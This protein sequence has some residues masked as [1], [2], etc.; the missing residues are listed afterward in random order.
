MNL[1]DKLRSA[2]N[3]IYTLQT[4]FLLSTTTPMFSQQKSSDNPFYKVANFVR[5]N[6]QELVMDKDGAP[7]YHYSDNPNSEFQGI[8]TYYDTNKNN[9]IDSL[10]ILTYL[11][12]IENFVY[13]DRGVNGYSNND[14]QGD[15]V[16]VMMAAKFIM[17]TIQ[18]IEHYEVA[19]AALCIKN[20]L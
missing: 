8:F 9:I 16:D 14:L 2:K 13:L 18:G 12:P 17:P 11:S 6:A 19:I 15:Y 5:H 4:A 10:D 3:V 20:N 1:F 7:V